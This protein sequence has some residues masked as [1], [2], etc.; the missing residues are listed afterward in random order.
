[1]ST[2]RQGKDRVIEKNSLWDGLNIQKG[3]LFVKGKI[4][5]KVL[6]LFGGFQRGFGRF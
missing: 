4:L 2:A 6:C 5:G 3:E 1:M